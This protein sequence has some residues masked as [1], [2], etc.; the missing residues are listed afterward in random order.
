[1]TSRKRIACFFTGGYTEINSMRIFLKKVNRNVDY[2]QL[3]P[4]GPRKSRS[5]IKT[6][7]S[8]ERNQNGLTGTSLINFVLEYVRNEKYHFRDEQYD[9]ILIEDD[10]DDRFLSISQ[11][12]TSTLNLPDWQAH[13]QTI[14]NAIHQHY[15]SIPVFFI[16]AAPEVEAW[17]L[18]DWNNS[19]GR[20]YQDDNTLTSELNN[21]FSVR[22]RQYVNT[23]IVTAHYQ[24]NI[25]AYGYFNGIYQK[26]S[27]EIQNALSSHDFLSEHPQHAPIRYSKKIH[28]EMMLENIDPEKVCQSCRIFF[29]NDYWNLSRL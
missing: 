22:F 29:G 19:F 1:M 14:T 5:S 10:K 6:R 16:Y 20:V 23:H 7:S 21:T 4:F 26:L 28:G 15:P 2:I 8:I 3:C 18:A 17:F 12:G 24:N 11:S 13:T 9:A 27:E 25:E